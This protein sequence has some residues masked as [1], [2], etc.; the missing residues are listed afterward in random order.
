M[1]ARAGEALVGLNTDV[2]GIGAALGGTSIEGER[3]VVIGAGGSARAAIVALASLG[4][5]ITILARDPAKAAPLLQ[6]ADHVTVRPLDAAEPTIAG[7]AAIVNASPLGMQGSPPMPPAFTA[8]LPLAAPGALA[9]DLVYHPVETRFLAAAAAAGLRTSD[10]LTVLIGQ[11]RPAFH[12]F[13]GAEP[14]PGDTELRGLLLKE[15]RAD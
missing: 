1:I 5:S 9:V 6:L 2:D 7:A 10:G 11:A 3:A 15:L 12:A 14:P 13:F 8:A 4:A